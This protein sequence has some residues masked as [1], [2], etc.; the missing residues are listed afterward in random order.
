MARDEYF[1]KYIERIL[2]P[3]L[4]FLRVG[5]GFGQ[6][7]YFVLV[8][9]DADSIL[10]PTILV[11]FYVFPYNASLCMIHFTDSR[12]YAIVNFK[13]NPYIGTTQFCK[14]RNIE[15]NF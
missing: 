9:V 12:L 14:F 6:K 3:H 2:L 8:Y 13:I 15:G 11:L 10:V 5:D 7:R 4:T 1:H